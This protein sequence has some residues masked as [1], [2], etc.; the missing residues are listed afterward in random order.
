MQSGTG[1]V[2]SSVTGNT[3][4]RPCKSADETKPGSVSP[5]TRSHL[6]EIRENAHR[7]ERLHG[8]QTS[9]KL[10]LS[11]PESA[12]GRTETQTQ[13]PEDWK[14]LAQKLLFSESKKSF[15]TELRSECDRETENTSISKEVKSKNGSKVRFKVN[16]A[17]TGPERIVNNVRDYI[18]FSPTRMASARERSRGDLSVSVLTP[19]PGLDVSSL[20]SSQ[21]VTGGTFVIK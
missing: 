3:W 13:K 6:S 16:R 15:R 21:H 2:D 4:N 5:G 14:D 18:L 7:E 20:C 10:R 17:A 11:S 1:C 19:P 12:R 9:E 8:A